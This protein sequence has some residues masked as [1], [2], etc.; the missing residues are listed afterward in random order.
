MLNKLCNALSRVF[1]FFLVIAKAVF[2]IVLV[3]A[4][5]H[6]IQTFSH[7]PTTFYFLWLNHKVCGKLDYYLDFLHANGNVLWGFYYVKRSLQIKRRVIP[8]TF[9]V[10]FKWEVFCRIT[11]KSCLKSKVFYKS[12]QTSMS[13]APSWVG[14]LNKFEVLFYHL[15]EIEWRT[16]KRASK[17]SRY[18]HRY[19]DKYS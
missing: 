19:N 11:F 2:E 7:E 18:S 10:P 4:W 5:S 1:C 15:S 14:R 17:P 13:P 9:P 6:C 12:M 3:Q 8:E 16:V